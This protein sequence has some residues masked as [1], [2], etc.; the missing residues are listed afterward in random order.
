MNTVAKTE[1]F[2]IPSNQPVRN[3]KRADLDQMAAKVS[4]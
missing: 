2:V 1:H 3:L 4:N